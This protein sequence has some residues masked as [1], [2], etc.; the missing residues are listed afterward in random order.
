MDFDWTT[1]AFQLVNVLVLLAILWRFLFRPVVGIIGERQAA[2]GRTLADAE[3]A[4]AEAAAAEAAAR[5]EAEKIAAAR[6][7][8][9]ERARQDAEAQRAAILEKARDD[10][11]AIAAEAEAAMAAAREEAGQEMLARARELSLAI[12]ERLMQ[13]LPEDRRVG[14]YAARLADTLGAL[15]APQREALFDAQVPRLVAPRPLSDVD[16]A[17]ARAA[18]A[19]WLVG[20]PPVE[21]DPGLIAGL[22]LRGRHG[23]VENSIRHDLT[24]IA[25]AMADEH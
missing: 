11:A 13:G 5:S 4:K 3:S 1:F 10:A 7:D 15:P 22:E 12:A 2:I 17:E 19:P 18:L 9:L 20:E 21:V 23:V 14:G 16:L 25:E 8:L 6:R 24:R